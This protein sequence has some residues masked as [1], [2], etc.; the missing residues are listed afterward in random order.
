M[1]ADTA[2]ELIWVF[3]GGGTGGGVEW[4]EGRG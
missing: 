2:G 4:G 1:L 3:W